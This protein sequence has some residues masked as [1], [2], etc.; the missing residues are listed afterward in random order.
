MAINPEEI[1]TVQVNELPPAPFSDSSMLAHAVGDI[2]SRGTIAELVTF[3]QSKLLARPYELKVLV[4]DNSYI[5]DNFD[6]TVG[7]TQ[8]I[9]KV[10]GLWETWAICNGNNG[11]EN[12]D[13]QTLIG[14]GANY[15]TLKTFLGSATHTLTT[16]Q[17]PAHFHHTPG[18]VFKS[19][20]SAAGDKTGNVSSATG[21]DSGS[22]TELAIGNLSTNYNSGGAALE[23]TVGS[24]Q[25]H[26]NM[27][28]SM[29][30]LM[31]M[32]LP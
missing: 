15:P 10:G 2:L 23:Q 17:M 14:F 26:N 5:N 30:V 18:S 13:G 7:A 3:I 27:Q 4:V 21:Y 16:A 32:K 9:G 19:F 24:G 22:N 6:M 25:A 29:V 20:V 31:I 11:T 8:G 12:L 28:P 1:T